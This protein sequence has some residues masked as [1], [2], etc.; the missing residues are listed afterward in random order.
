MQLAHKIT[1]RA[2]VIDDNHCETH[3][4]PINIKSKVIIKFINKIN[5]EK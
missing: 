1:L 4:I 5:D 2:W 3:K